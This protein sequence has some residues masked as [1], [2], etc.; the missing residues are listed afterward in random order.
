[1]FKVKH[2]E[3]GVVYTVYGVNGTNSDTMFLLDDGGRKYNCWYWDYAEHY[4]PID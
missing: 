1:M 4:F 3:T 2:R